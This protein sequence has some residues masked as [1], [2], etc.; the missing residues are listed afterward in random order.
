MG[1]SGDDK[2][3]RRSTTAAYSPGEAHHAKLAAGTALRHLGDRRTALHELG[4][5]RH[6]LSIVLGRLAATRLRLLGLATTASR[7][8]LRREP[9]QISRRLFT[10]ARV[11]VHVCDA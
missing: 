2:I 1:I 6:D 8:L 9:H 5:A 11:N 10:R 3:E 4:G 7:S